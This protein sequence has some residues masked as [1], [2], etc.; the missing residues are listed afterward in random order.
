MASGIKESYQ[1]NFKLRIVEDT[2]DTIAISTQPRFE[3]IVVT[4]DATTG[5]VIVGWKTLLGVG[6]T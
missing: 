1:P 6:Q 5:A 3:L 2:V 4:P